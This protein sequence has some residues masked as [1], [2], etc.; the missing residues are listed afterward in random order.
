METSLFE[1]KGDYITITQLMKALS[2]VGGGS[3]A[4]FWIS[5]GTVYVNDERI[6]EKRKKLYPGD[7]VEWKEQ[8]VELK[9]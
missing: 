1:I 8:K 3:E 2:W 5:E 7:V 4:H 9:S 6:Q